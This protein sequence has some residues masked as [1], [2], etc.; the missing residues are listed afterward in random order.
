[1]EAVGFEPTSESRADLRPSALVNTIRPLI[2]EHSPHLLKA[3]GP[4]KTPFGHGVAA[5]AELD[6]GAH[7]R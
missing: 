2:R 7:Q 4:H 1:M 5:V 6:D 3:R